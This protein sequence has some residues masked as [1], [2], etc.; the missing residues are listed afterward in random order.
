MNLQ[1]YNHL[2]AERTTLH[3][4]LERT[5]VEDVLDRSSL[6]SRIEI[7]EH[8]LSQVTPPNASPNSR[9]SPP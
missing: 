2:L 6:Q 1:E 5:P 7:V 4:M 9:R 8:E 3:R